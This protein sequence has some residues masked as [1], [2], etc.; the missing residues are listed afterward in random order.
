MTWDSNSWN[1]YELLGIVF[2]HLAFTK[3]GNDW[4]KSPSNVPTVGMNSPFGPQE[5]VVLLQ[6]LVSRSNFDNSGAPKSAMIKVVPFSMEYIL[7]QNMF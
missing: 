5:D 2:Q 7:E 4:I 1:E 6:Q 3:A